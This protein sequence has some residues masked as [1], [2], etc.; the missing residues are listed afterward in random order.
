MGGASAIYF[1]LEQQ[2]EEE[3]RCSVISTKKHILSIS[4]PNIKGMY[5]LHHHDLQITVCCWKLLC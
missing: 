4:E 3:E 5:R 2:A 1:F